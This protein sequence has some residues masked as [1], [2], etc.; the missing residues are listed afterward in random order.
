MPVTVRRASAEADV[1]FISERFQETIALWEDYEVTPES[2]RKQ[3]ETVRKWI[4][5]EKM[6]ITVAELPGG[7]LAGF[8]SLYVMKD[9]AGKPLGKIIILYVL[10]GHRG[11]GIAKELKL[12]GEDWL[13]GKGVGQV[14]TEIDAKNER[15]LEITRAAG[16]RPK[17]HSFVRDL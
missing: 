8:N 5:D 12:E 14:L 13:R 11:K 3:A 7:E 15:M 16:F 17:S 10:P 4:T 6:H 2:V 1:A 9:Y